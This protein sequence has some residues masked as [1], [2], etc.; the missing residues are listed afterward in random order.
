MIATTNLALRF[1]LELAAIAALAFAGLQGFDG[2]TRWLVAIGAPAALV[3]FWAF[4]VAPGATNPI[5]PALRE[6]IGSL[7]LLCA[8][9]AMALAGHPKLAITFAVLIVTNNV[10]LALMRDHATGPELAR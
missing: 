1:V 8:A 6:V 7:A 4:V 3:L 5:A 10:L 9:G 2:P